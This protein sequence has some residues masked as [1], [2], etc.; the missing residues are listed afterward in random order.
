LVRHYKTHSGELCKIAMV[1]S[2]CCLASW[3]N[4]IA[5]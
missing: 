4:V 1:K 2:F 5:S 3:K